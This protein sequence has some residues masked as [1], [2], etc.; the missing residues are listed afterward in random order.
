MKI[1][2]ASLVSQARKKSCPAPREDADHQRD[3]RE[4]EQHERDD[5]GEDHRQRERAEQRHRAERAEEDHH[6]ERQPLERAAGLLDVDRGRVGLV[7]AV[8]GE[9]RV[10][11]R[12]LAL[13]SASY[14]AL[15]SSEPGAWRR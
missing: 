13:R 14:S 5:L 8:A 6:R 11:A 4:A 15:R 3:R 12:R 10:V 2:V 9:L 1:A 7:D